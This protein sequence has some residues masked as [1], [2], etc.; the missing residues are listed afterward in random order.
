MFS[1]R[2]KN[3][4]EPEYETDYNA[5]KVDP[6]PATAGSLLR[7]VEPVIGMALKSYAA[8]DKT[9]LIRGRAKRLVLDSLKTYDPTQAGLRTHL[10]QNLQR[11]SRVRQ[12]QNNFIRIPEQRALDSFHLAR[13]STQLEDELGYEPSDLEVADHLGWSLKRIGGS[14]GLPHTVNES[15]DRF[16]DEEGNLGSPA[17][18]AFDQ[19]R[20]KAWEGYVYHGL[21][22]IDQVIM[23][24]SLGLNGKPRLSNGDIAK[25]LKLSGGAISQRSARI[26]KQLNAFY[27]AGVF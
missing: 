6:T 24:S 4:I 5:W 23:E 7:K 18:S 3:T 12:E 27:E 14:R 2:S 19:R 15:S 9:P 16:R 8:D 22:P 10:M 25:R 21:D 26:Q 11:L 13:A 17:S 20:F 1:N